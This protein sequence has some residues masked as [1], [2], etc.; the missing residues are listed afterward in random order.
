M[1]H[2]RSLFIAAMVLIASCAKDGPPASYYDS[3][4]LVSAMREDELMLLAVRNAK[5]SQLDAKDTA[6]L[7]RYDFPELTDIAA[8]RI[9]DQLTVTEF[10][11]AISYFQSAGGR[12]LV[13]RLELERTG[14][15][16]GTEQLTAAEQAELDKFKQRS[17]GR[18]LLE[19]RI[20]A[21]TTAMTEATTRFD[22]YVENCQYERT[23]ESEGIEPRPSCKS[24][25]LASADNVCLA[26]Y[27]VEGSGKSR[28]A[29]VE[30]ECRNNGK[31][32]RSEVTLP[33]P[34]LPIALR[35]SP[36]RELEILIQNDRVRIVA[37]DDGY[38]A[39]RFRFASRKPSDPPVLECLTES[40]GAGSLPMSIT[41][42]GWRAHHRP[43]VCFMTARVPKEEV[44]GA[45]QDMML[46][47]RRHETV[48]LPFATSQLVFI[49]QVREMN[50]QPVHVELGSTPLTLISQQPQLHVLTG[51]EAEG[52]LQS[53][54]SQPSQLTVKS[55][56][57]S[58]YSIPVSRQD[59]DFAYAGFSACLASL[60]ST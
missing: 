21:D 4:R 41:M 45:D 14:Q 58:S 12:K 22:L 40:R 8:R 49:A 57:G 31:T 11:D 13:R 51:K 52:L 5:A 47:F 30:V 23:T 6:C 54:A 20:T 48:T 43:G 26:N 33:D 34:Q 1:F 27:A 60:K 15:A 59:F 37:S 53:L 36:S 3:L 9:S 19:D 35:W 44:P 16:A 10:E 50:E 56:A 39:Q 42:A 25:S 2:F 18:K 32:L 29:S 46:Q 24:K 17:A 28:K 55:N 38:S 7:A